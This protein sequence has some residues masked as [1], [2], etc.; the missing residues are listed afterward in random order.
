MSDTATDS[1]IRTGK[2]R[3]YSGK[4]Y[5]VI[6][7]VHHTETRERMVLYRGLYDSPDLEREYGVD[8]LFVRPY[9]M[10]FGNVEVNG[11]V[12]PRFTYVGM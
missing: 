12:Q 11:V 1:R 3:H 7:V 4:Y 5:N 6:D 8:P 2:Y 9:A 10:F